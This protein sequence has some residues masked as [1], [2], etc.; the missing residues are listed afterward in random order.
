MK[1]KEYVAI[2]CKDAECDYCFQNAQYMY[3]YKA[4]YNSQS[5]MV[6]AERRV[7]YIIKKMT[8]F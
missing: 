2:W 4:K 7:N 8:I 5:G 6:K 3:D 1:S